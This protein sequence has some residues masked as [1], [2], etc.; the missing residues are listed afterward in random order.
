M[1]KLA[2]AIVMLA[3]GFMVL[4]GCSTVETAKNFNDQDIAPGNEKPVAHINVD[5]FGYYLFY[6]IPIVSSDPFK[7]NSYTLFKDTVNVK[8]AVDLLTKTAG[9]TGSNK[10][11][12][13]TSS[14]SSTGKFSLWIIWYRD[15]Q[16]SGNA[17]L[18]P[19]KKK[20]K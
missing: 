20:K 13:L 6:Y 15:A 11:T 16:V 9:E 3:V 12:D 8:N 18:D 14:T 17:V 2:V 10:V 19:G 7:N 1:K 4:A 5:L